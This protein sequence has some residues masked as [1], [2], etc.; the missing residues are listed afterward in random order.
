MHQVLEKIKAA[1]H[2]VLITHMNPDADSMGSASAFYSYLLQVQ[3]KITLFSY[4]K[5]IDPRLMFLPWVDKLKHSV[6][7]SCD[8]AISFDC[9]SL[10]RLG[11]VVDIELIN[12]DHHMS[13]ERFACLNVVDESAISTTRV[14]YDYFISQGV[15]INPKMATAL[16]AGL[17]DDSQNFMS[18]KTDANTFAMAQTLLEKGAD[19][20]AVIK[21]LFQTSPL[22]LLRLKGLMFSN[23][24]LELNA[25]IVVHKVT[26][27]MLDATGAVFGDCE[28]ALEASLYLPTVSVALLFCELKDGTIKG[29]IRTDGTIDASSIADNYDGGGHLHAAGFRCSHTT[30]D[31]ACQ[32]LIKDILEKKK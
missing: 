23:M 5:A 15:K 6:P 25:Q 20:S 10:S 4:T 18:D 28:A 26:Q 14:I 31:D 9:G 13:N 29:S 2:I 27:A 30:L 16:Y 11:V 32:K 22:S 19:K 17:V 7:K 1:K 8:L 21:H 3:K 24:V 12:F